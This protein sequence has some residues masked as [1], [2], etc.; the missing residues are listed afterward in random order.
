M[1]SPWVAASL[2]LADG[3]VR[4]ALSVTAVLSDP[5]ASAM[6]VIRGDRIGVAAGIGVRGE[7]QG[8]HVG[9]AGG[10]ATRPV[11]A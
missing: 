4:L 2:D 11:S 5:Q 1:G 8:D 3:E 6:N 9:I 10:V 7:R